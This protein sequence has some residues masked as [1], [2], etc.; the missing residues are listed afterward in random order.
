ML[1][2]RE[3]HSILKILS[4]LS[5]RDAPKS[6]IRTVCIQY[7]RSFLVEVFNACRR[8]TYFPRNGR[9]PQWSW[10]QRLSLLSREQPPPYFSHVECFWVSRT[11]SS[12]R[13]SW[14]TRREY[15]WIMTFERCIPPII[16]W[17]GWWILD[18]IRSASPE[19]DQ[20]SHGQTRV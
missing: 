7:H 14:K 8:L 9:P 3:T 5:W 1:S 10:Y 20:F 12:M 11:A 17:W 13:Q 6:L 19:L 2:K 4:L 16:N 18:G 15:H